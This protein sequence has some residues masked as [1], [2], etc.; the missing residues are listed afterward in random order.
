MLTVL[1]VY[2]AVLATCTLLDRHAGVRRPLLLAM[3][4]LLALDCLANTLLLQS[5]RKTL[6]GE[7]WHHR[8]HKY[9]GWCYRVINAVFFW[10]TDHCRTQAQRE[11]RWGSVWAA[12]WRNVR[13]LPL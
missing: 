8:E 5:W 12:W 11:A 10:Q 7:A 6:S 2:A 3:L 13:G 1:T 4:P 9:W